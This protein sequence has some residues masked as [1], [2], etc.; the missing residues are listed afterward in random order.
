MASDLFP[1]AKKGQFCG[2]EKCHKEQLLDGLAVT[3]DDWTFPQRSWEPK[4][5]TRTN[6][7]RDFAFLSGVIPSETHLPG[8][9]E[10]ETQE[11]WG[12]LKAPSSSERPLFQC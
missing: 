10:E 3:G 1:N 5:S 12:G 6:G 4:F 9:T 8:L 11:A 7:G 2:T